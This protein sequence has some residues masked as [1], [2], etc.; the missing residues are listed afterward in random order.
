MSNSVDQAF[1][2]KFEEEVKLAYQ[3]MG[4]KLVNT[5]RTKFN[6]GAKDTTFQKIGK[7]AAGQKSRHGLVPLMNLDHTNVTATLAD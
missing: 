3:R 2:K 6:I 1:I 4:S 5:V 7:G